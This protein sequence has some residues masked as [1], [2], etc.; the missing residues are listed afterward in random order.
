MEPMAISPEASNH[1]LETPPAELKA[2][3]TPQFINVEA[4][5]E[6]P[7]PKSLVNREM[8]LL[9]EKIKPSSCGKKRNYST[10][11][12]S[13]D[14]WFLT[15]DSKALLKLDEPPSLAD[16]LGPEVEMELRLLGCELIQTGSI[17]LKLPQTAAA[18]G[19]ILFQRYYYQKSFVRYNML[20]TVMACLLLA[21]RI[22][23]APRRPRDVINV[24]NRLKQL[25]A[26]RNSSNSRSGIVPLKIDKNYV[27]LK[28]LVIKTE[29]R[30]LNVLG[31]VVHVHHPHKLIYAYMHVLQ[32]LD[33]KDILYKAWNYMNDGLR[34][35]IFL[36]YRSETIACACIFLAART[37]ENPVALPKE[38]RPW[39]EL[40]DSS[41]EDVLLIAKT[42]MKLYTMP[43]VPDLTRLNAHVEQLFKA[44]YKPQAPKDVPKPEPP[45]EESKPPVTPDVK[46]KEKDK[47]STRRSGDRC[48]SSKSRDRSRR[49]PD[50]RNS[51]R[52]DRRRRRSRDRDSPRRRR[53]R[54]PPPHRQKR[55]RSRSRSRDRRR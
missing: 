38:P 15:L 7:A 51:S 6:E 53:S 14:K 34:T 10:I 17:L 30:L 13:A 29:R 36:R 32:L 4:E 28:N 44:K 48:S 26:R 21:S 1:A 25:H 22:E 2:A 24:V 27:E 33:R 39:F 42:L 35:D 45:Q 5:N 11:D 16:G 43:K 50:D 9:M 3:L 37:V 52:R 18:T 46:S 31:F 23:E 8:D 47:T 49:S 12:I 55:R 54:S 40:Y 41:E 20:H 19:Q